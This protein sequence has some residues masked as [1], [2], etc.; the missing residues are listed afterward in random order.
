[1]E[2]KQE[3]KFKLPRSIRNSVQFSESANVKLSNT[4]FL[5]LLSGI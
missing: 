1:M 5:T 3:E 4:C 2:T